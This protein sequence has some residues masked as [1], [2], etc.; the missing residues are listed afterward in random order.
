MKK[1][2]LLEA[3]GEF[4]RL[5]EQG[6][7]RAVGRLNGAGQHVPIPE[8]YWISAVLSPFS[9]NNQEISEAI[10]AVPNPDKIPTYKET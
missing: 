10:P 2:V 1:N 9:L 5:A 8:T 3:P 4:K 6:K 7:F